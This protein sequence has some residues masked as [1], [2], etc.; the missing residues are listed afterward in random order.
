MREMQFGGDGCL[1]DGKGVNEER[2]FIM[3]KRGRVE[4]PYTV[5]EAQLGHIENILIF[6]LAGPLRLLLGEGGRAKFIERK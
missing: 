1:L 3:G 6:V 5:P 2:L 4:T